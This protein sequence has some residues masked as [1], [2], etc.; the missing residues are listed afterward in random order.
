MA[1]RTDMPL[2]TR[3][4]IATQ[5]L[6][7][8]RGRGEATALAQQHEVSRT[9]VYY[10]ADKAAWVLAAGMSP[11]HG[12]APTPG[13]VSVTTSRLKRAVVLLSLVGVSQR[14]TT[15]ALAELLDTQRSAGYVAQVLREAE[16]LATACNA[17]LTPALSGLL[18]ADEVFLHD[19]PI[20][21]LVH[22]AS[23]F[24]AGLRLETQRDGPTWGCQFLDAP[25][26]AGVISDAGS[27][28]AAGAALAQ[29]PCHVGDWMHPLLQAGRVEAQ[30]ERQAYAALAAQ[31]TREDKLRRTHTAKRWAHHWEKYLS[32]CAAA[33]QA[34]A[35]YDQWHTQR[36]HLRATAAQFDWATGEVR[37]PAQVQ[38]ELQTL[39]TAFAQC[40]GGSQAE[41]L[42]RALAHQAAALTTALP[43]LQTALAPLTA[44]WGEEATRHVCRL[45]QA[46][47][48]WAFPG[49]LPAQ[50]HQLEQAITDSLAWASAHLGHRLSTL[51]NLVAT[52]L[53]QWPRTSSAIE[54]LNSLL[55]P[56]LNGRKHVSQGFLEL[57]RFFH[58][59]HVF[60]RGP[61]AGHSPLELAGGP[62]LA[63]PLAALGL[64]SK[65]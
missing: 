51:Q 29:V 27:G 8:T 50:R 21:G 59:T 13:V 11:T 55:R 14:D 35:C 9:M 53:A 60:Q 45:W 36:C 39:H 10:L 7:P 19:Q 61:R 3:I 24:V 62:H 4:A 52:L 6:S 46:L 33:D 64:G 30:L 47:Q 63:D 41:A 2:E 5:M 65:A 56:F 54:C 20:L 15:L 43:H 42:V 37:T 25:A 58:N 16:A 34:V 26:G 57:F 32:A 22:P 38:A 40:A 1:A 49:W 44:A 18:A 17:E 23:L 12:P 48:D 31:Y 28:L